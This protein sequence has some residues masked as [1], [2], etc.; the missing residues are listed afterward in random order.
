MPPGFWELH[1]G[2]QVSGASVHWVE[3][4]LD[5]GA[6]VHQQ[7]LPIDPLVSY[8][9][10]AVSLDQLGT[11]MLLE[12]L[13]KIDCGD[14]QA[15]DQ[16]KPTTPTRGN[17]PF[18]A[19]VRVKRKLHQARNA[20]DQGL[21]QVARKIAKT[22]AM[23]AFVYA[24]APAR[25]FVRSL[26]GECHTIVLLFHRVSDSYLDT[27]TVGVEQFRDQMRF[28][29]SRYEIL[30][31][32]TMLNQQGHARKRPAVVITFDDGYADNHVAARLL[33]REAIPATF[34]ISTRIVG[35]ELP[36]P[37]DQKRLGRRVPSLEWNQVQELADWGI[38]DRKPH[39]PSRRRC[40]VAAGGG[41][42]GNPSGLARFGRALRRSWSSTVARLSVRRQTEHERGRA[43]QAEFA[44]N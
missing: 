20:A 34:F 8:A 19:Q 13:R 40:L 30:D 41:R 15:I 33:R 4:G 22:A 28:V 9:G 27:V 36:F 35:S 3:K 39:V 29:A 2:A 31:L 11:E 6:I 14:E 42:F 43:Q 5:T 10:L 24:W 18:L 26:R 38:C 25:N 21:V 44:G 12:A 7:S 32:A 1:D 23:V 37:H 17:P 16:R